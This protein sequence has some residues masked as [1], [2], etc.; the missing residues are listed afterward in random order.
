MSKLLG[1]TVFVPWNMVV[2]VA[3]IIF[4]YFDIYRQTGHF[5]PSWLL[6]PVPGNADHLS[7]LQ[8]LLTNELTP[9]WGVFDKLIATRLV[10]KFLACCCNRSSMTTFTA[11]KTSDLAAIYRTCDVRWEIDRE[12]WIGKD[13]EVTGREGL[14]RMT[15]CRKSRQPTQSL[16]SLVV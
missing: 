15:R 6:V 4:G 13:V 8:G 10:K 9:W 7:W 2:G 11:V 1:R 16:R 12:R 5:A 3:A 14:T